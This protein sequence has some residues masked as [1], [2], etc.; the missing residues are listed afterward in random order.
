MSDEDAASQLQTLLDHIPHLYSL[1]FNLWSENHILYEK[2]TA[3]VLQTRS[4]R[5]VNLRG[6]NHWFDDEECTQISYSS[7]GKHC[8]VLFI[9]VKHQRNIIHLI[10]MMSNLRTLIVQSFDDDDGKNNSFS[11][12]DRFVRWL[13]QNLPSTCSIKRDARF[14]HSIRIWIHT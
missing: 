5:R 6:Y 13:Q 12:E 9:K 11:I 2:L 14:G 4:I 8:Q 3:L 10:N 7:L 1:K